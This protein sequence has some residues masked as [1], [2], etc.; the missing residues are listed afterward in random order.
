MKGVDLESAIQITSSLFREILFWKSVF[1]FRNFTNE[2]KTNIYIKYKIIVLT[3]S[4]RRPL[5]YRNQYINL[6]RK[7][8]NWFLYDNGL[9]HER[10]KVKLFLS[11]THF[12]S[13]NQKCLI[14]K[15]WVFFKICVLK[16]SDNLFQR[17]SLYDCLCVNRQ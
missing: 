15:T 3:L 9:R 4:W 8:M 2:K 11:L 10:V 13:T 5:S 14:F 17:A 6:L 12:T 16:I 7:S 1:N